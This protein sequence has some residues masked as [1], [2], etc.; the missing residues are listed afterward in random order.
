MRLLRLLAGVVI[1]GRRRKA[2]DCVVG[3]E[4][5]GGVREGNLLFTL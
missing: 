5:Y 4:I 1:V 2:V 3:F